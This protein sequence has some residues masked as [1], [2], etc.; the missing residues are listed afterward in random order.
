MKLKIAQVIGLN[1]DQRA[2][3]VRSAVRDDNSF[4]A[5]LLLDSDDAFTKGR[6]VLSELE[7]FY[8]EF[9]GAVAEKFKATF[10]KAEEKLSKEIDFELCLAAVSGKVL[11]IIG[12]GQVEVYLKRADKLSS[13]L[14]VGAPSQLIS[15]FIAAG[16][17]LLLSTKSLITLLGSEIDKTLSLPIETFEEEIE[18]RIGVSG[19]ENHGLAALAVEVIPS[20]PLS[21]EM[22][23]E[24]DLQ[25][26]SLSSDQPEQK[27]DQEYPSRPVILLQTV[28]Q[29]MAMFLGRLRGY[30]PRSGRGRLILAVALIVVIASG[31]GYKYKLS[32][33]QER[34][35]Q[36]NKI[37]QEAKDDFNAAKGLSSLNPAEAKFKLDGARDKVNKA[38]MIK[39]KDTEAENLKKQIEQDSSSILQQSSVS[40]FPE[41]LD[42]D[43][44]KKNFH[45]EQ[46]SL[47]SGKLL[48]LDPAVKTLVVVDL[49]KKSNQILA[50]SEQL[51][52]AL[53][54]SLNGGL[55]LVYSKDKGILK[56]DTTNQKLSTVAKK[57]SGWGEIKDIYGFA[58]NVYLLDSGNSATHSTDAQGRTEQ[59]RS[60][61]SSGQIWKY[62]PT[63]EGYS[64]KREYL[65]KNT[66][67]DFTGVLRMQIE[68]SIYVLKTGG[69]I[70]RFTRGAKDNFSLG[71]LDKGVKDPKSFFT[72]SDTDNLY[73]LDSGNSRVLILTKT[74]SYKGQ[75]TGNRF[76]TAT[77]LVVD[78]KG[79]KVYLLEGSRIY[80]V[81]LK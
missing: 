58:G 64:D 1:T 47:S 22:V 46:L 77:D 69:E 7:D 3:Q 60:A 24:E 59:S 71:G 39:P 13:L 17:R 78:E 32:R 31:L 2:A 38:L 26:T 54:A 36:F 16:D 5:V 34:K 23:G 33:D 12:K 44:V 30:F 75:I 63:S 41:F 37:L 18:G 29:K 42:L 25:I 50:G 11:Y 55:A 14:S 35:L 45:A 15:G 49:A 73:L 76:A 62:L 56:I 9:E 65:T 67:V 10:E 19:L 74:G 27:I 53:F 52:D 21:E 6:Q 81:D 79:K 66:K 57:D 20:A 51:G 40:D 68:S 4:L 28:L 61:T 43:L 72:S 8:F 48:I 70:L 80:T